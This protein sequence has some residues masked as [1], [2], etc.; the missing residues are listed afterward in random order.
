MN[1][2][3]FIQ[4]QPSLQR[5]K[6][7]GEKKS[8]EEMQDRLDILALPVV[9]DSGEKQDPFSVR[10][11]AL[12]YQISDRIKEIA[13]RKITREAYPPKD[14]TAV[15]PAAI[16][17]IREFPFQNRTLEVKRK[18]PQGTTAPKLPRGQLLTPFFSHATDSHPRQ[19]GR[20]ASRTGDW[21]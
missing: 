13:I 2:F 10:P 14:P 4:L 3:P 5:G 8:I 11:S 21:P 17:A 18:R 16:K 12:K 9:K 19:A 7:R 1:L 6:D 15:S 20:Q